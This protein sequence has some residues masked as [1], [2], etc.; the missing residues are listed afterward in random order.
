MELNW[1]LQQ[2][3]V[4]PCRNY[5]QQSDLLERL[6]YNLNT[7]N[8]DVLGFWEKKKERMKRPLLRV[9]MRALENKL[10]KIR[11]CIFKLSIGHGVSTKQ[12]LQAETAETVLLERGGLLI[13][14]QHHQV[15]ELDWHD[16]FGDGE[17]EGVDKAGDDRV[18]V[19][20]MG[21]A[22]G[23]GGRGARM[24]RNTSE[25]LEGRVGVTG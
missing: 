8:P 4:D 19:A 17:E 3:G 25:D 12:A 22:E 6:P 13:V 1:S 24:G 18:G 21:R 2:F 7:I 10:F 11:L 14:E 9:F 15:G 16:D 20:V 5:C 23:F